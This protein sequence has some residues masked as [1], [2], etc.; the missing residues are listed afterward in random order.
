MNFV[1]DNVLNDDVMLRANE[2]NVGG[3]KLYT[4]TETVKEKKKRNQSV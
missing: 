1:L 4:D 2:K 3:K